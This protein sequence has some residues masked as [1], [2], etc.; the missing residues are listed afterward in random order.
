MEIKGNITDALSNQALENIRIDFVLSEV[1]YRVY[2][3]TEK[4]GNYQFSKLQHTP[5]FYLETKA[6]GYFNER[7]LIE[8]KGGQNKF[9]QDF[10][11]QPVSIGSSKI[12]ED[13]HFEVGKAIIKKEST[14]ELNSLI[15]FLKTHPDYHVEISGHTDNIG[16]PTFNKKLSEQRAIAIVNYVVEHGF[17]DKKRLQT[18]GYGSE[19]PIT[20]NSTEEKRK[21]NRRVEIKIVK[22]RK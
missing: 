5:F 20:D 18:K 19:K 14:A 9:H 4:Q 16:D 11:L 21:T 22:D 2:E 12:L 13:L 15:D 17:V 8:A 6:Q 3:N 10:K 1:N 7:I